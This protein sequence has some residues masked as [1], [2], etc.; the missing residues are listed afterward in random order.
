[1]KLTYIFCAALIASSSTAWAIDS[2]IAPLAAGKPAGVRQAQ[3]LDDGNGMLVVAGAALIGITIALATNNSNASQPV[4]T[5]PAGG[6]S[7]TTTT[8]TNP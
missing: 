1:M 5:A 4:G 2:S 3:M 7:T 8:G 6:G